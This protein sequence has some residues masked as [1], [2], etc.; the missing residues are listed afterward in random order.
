MITQMKLHISAVN[1]QKIIL[2]HKYVFLFVA[3]YVNAFFEVF[4]IISD[5]KLSFA[6]FPL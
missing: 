6:L 2:A 3:L 5:I 4:I 1:K